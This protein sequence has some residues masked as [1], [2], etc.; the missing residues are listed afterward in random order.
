MRKI[1]SI[2]FHDDFERTFLETTM[3]WGKKCIDEEEMRGDYLDAINDSMS[4]IHILG[5][6]ESLLIV[7]RSKTSMYYVVRD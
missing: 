6:Q 5:N 4:L 2:Y 1:G 7:N 3:S